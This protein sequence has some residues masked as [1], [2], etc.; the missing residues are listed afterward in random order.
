MIDKI[1]SIFGWKKYYVPALLVILLMGIFAFACSVSAEGAVPAWANPTTWL[2]WEISKTISQF[3]WMVDKS[4]DVLVKALVLV[5]NIGLYLVLALV[6]FIGWFL[7]PEFYTWQVA[8]LSEFFNQV[9]ILVSNFVYLFFA[10]LLVWIAF[11]NIIWKEGS[12][13]QLKTALPKFI[14]SVLIVPFTWFIVSFTLSFVSVASQTILSLPEDLIERQ[15]DSFKFKP[16]VID[17]GADYAS[18]DKYYTFDKDNA[19]EINITESLTTNPYLIV[20]RYFADTVTLQNNEQITEDQFKT[21]VSKFLISAIFSLVFIVLSFALFL[22]L[23]TRIVRLW[24]YTMFSPLFAISFFFWGKG[25]WWLDKIS[26]K[27]FLSIAFV[28]VYVSLAL[29]FGYIVMEKL[30]SADTYKQS[31]I[32]TPTSI[33][34]DEKTYEIGSFSLVLKWSIF[35]DAPEWETGS[36]DQN[37][38][39]IMQILIQ[40]L[41][42]VVF[43]LAIMAALR[44]NDITKT[45]VD[46]IYSV[47]KNIGNAMQSL[48]KHTP[49]PF[50]WGYSLEMASKATAIPMQVISNNT[51]RKAASISDQ[52]K[53]QLWFGWAISDLELAQIKEVANSSTATAEDVAKLFDTF[54]AKQS[55]YGQN[56][57]TVKRL[58]KFLFD[59]LQNDKSGAFSKY[60]LLAWRHGWIANPT[61]DVFK[62]GKITDLGYQLAL[63]TNN[64]SQVNSFRNAIWTHGWTVRGKAVRNNLDQRFNDKSDT[65]I[66][67]DAKNTDTITYHNDNKAKLKE[68]TDGRTHVKRHDNSVQILYN[69]ENIAFLDIKAQ[70]NDFS[71]LTTKQQAQIAKLVHKDWL[72]FSETLEILNSIWVK[73]EEIEL[74][75]EIWKLSRHDNNNN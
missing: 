65:I 3:S 8:D 30:S 51:S 40:I 59:K 12:N 66:K 63:K 20:W 46:P 55:E 29:S 1:R 60:R 48:P 26:F 4:L 34:W 72:P 17:F 15:E 70:D 39:P 22:A 47:W 28:P 74:D 50:T 38:N 68:L 33:S 44:T 67:I 41:W 5:F 36:I 14:V 32:M 64:L 57:A 19:T 61:G 2:E 49:I 37:V 58:R 69:G 56:E 11:V 24:L 45:V 27:S 54:V 10:G 13:Y 21:Q 42:I 62:D 53:S 31:S 75:T 9:W 18:G 52:M 25:W 43:R 73:V 6:Y 71:K 7:S 16:V 23:A 35:P